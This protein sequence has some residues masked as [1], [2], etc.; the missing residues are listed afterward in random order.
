MSAIGYTGS[1]PALVKKAGDTM[2]GPLVLSTDP[3]VNLGAATKQFVVDLASPQT[4]TGVKT[5]ASAPVVP[6]GAFPES[7]VANLPTDLGTLTTGIGAE[8]TRAQAAESTLS[9]SVAAK[10]VKPTPGIPAGDMTSAVQTSLGLANSALQSAPVTSVAGKTGAVALV[11][12]D[13]ANLSTDLAAKATDSAVV[14]LAGPESITGVKTFTAAPVLPAGALPESVVAN[15]G[16]DLAARYVKPGTGIPSTDMTSAVQTS[17]GLA[18]SALQTAPVTSV[19]TR[20][21]AVTLGAADVGA[22]TQ[23]TADGRYDALGAAATEATRAL[24]A[25][26]ANATAIAAKASPLVAT[27]VQTSAYAAAANQLVP[28][29]ATAAVFTVTLPSAPADKTRLVVKKVDTGANAVTVACAGTDVFNRA[30]GPTSLTLSVPGQAVTVQYVTT[31]GIWYISADDLPLAQLD[32]RYVKVGALL[33]SV[34]DNGAA[35]TGSTDDLAAIQ[36][37]VNSVSAAGGGIVYFPPASYLVSAPIV[38][39][40]NVTLLGAGPGSVLK[41]SANGSI[42]ASAAAAFNDFTIDNLTFIGPVNNTVTVPTR[43]RTT[44]GSG[45][46]IAV[47]VDGSLD[48]TGTFPLITNFVM[49]NCRVRNC[50]SLPIRIFGVTGVTS[51]TGC[52][53]TNNMDVGFGFNAEVICANNHSYS[54]ADNGF[55][56]SRGNQKVTCTGNTVENAAFYGIWLTGF[57]GTTGPQDFT[58]VGNVVKGCGQAGI[59]LMDAPKWGV[60]IGNMIDKLFYRGASGSPDDTTCCGIFVRGDSTSVPAP[61]TLSTGLLI[62]GNMIRQAAKAG[63][64]LT[65]ASGVKVSGNLLIDTGTQF[66]SDGVT[67][68]VASN[69]SQNV[70]IYV[71]TP[72]TSA[73]IVIT[74]NM[75]VDTRATPYTNW[76]IQPLPAVG[77]FT[78]GNTMLG[79]RN[80]SNLPTA[81]RSDTLGSL[82]GAQET[83]PRWAATNISNPSMPSGAVRFAYFTASASQTITKIS[84]SSSNTAAGATPSLV[85]YGIYS[86]DSSGNLTQLSQTANVTSVFAAPQNSYPLALAAS[87]ALTQGQ[88]YAIAAIVVTAAAAPT[89]AGVL[90]ATGVDN[91]FAPRLC[92]V[93]TAQSDLAASYTAGQVALSQSFAYAAALP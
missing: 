18:N 15:L 19:N 67:A 72:S 36:A 88:L 73:N 11:E 66:W 68:I 8:T 33:T 63:I 29:D 14:H 35:G 76:G 7:A 79:C 38:P 17:L 27:A 56:L 41:T 54:S 10:Y 57:T 78:A 75:T 43:A 48:T 34:K 93:L 61:A 71:D 89:V 2:T 40:S 25:E 49:R 6:S 1:D 86:V 74:D 62:A 92:G 51:V 26:A 69:T 55:S 20:T 91:A 81:V 32:T 39:A 44:S 23:A 22:L 84:L 30:V 47:S 42:V 64:Y 3:T 60:V 65:G 53:F 82:A 13:V 77:V 83:M 31:G 58:C 4:I 46:T 28:C 52:E 9:A 21:G 80:V 24:A 12:G 50:T 59:V 85:R 5:F 87:V 37:V 45:C 90:C 16:T 70:G